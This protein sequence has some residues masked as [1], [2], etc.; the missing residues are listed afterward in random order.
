MAERREEDGKSVDMILRSVKHFKQWK[1]SRVVV[2]ARPLTAANGRS[3][4]RPI[5]VPVFKVGP[6][7]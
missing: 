7:L 1:P 3:K 2:V 6:V 5:L 4:S